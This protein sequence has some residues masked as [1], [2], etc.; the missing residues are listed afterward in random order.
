MW[1]NWM[2][3]QSMRRVGFAQVA[4]C[5]LWRQALT[6]RTWPPPGACADFSRRPWIK[7]KFH[8]GTHVEGSTREW[9][10]W[11]QSILAGRVTGCGCPVIR[12]AGHRPSPLHQQK[13]HQRESI[14]MRPIRIIRFHSKALKTSYLSPPRLFWDSMWIVIPIAPYVSGTT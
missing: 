12:S 7:P 9:S 6:L 10:Q 14:K 11:V 8:W 1:E 2:R 4:R 5:Q 3:G 13:S